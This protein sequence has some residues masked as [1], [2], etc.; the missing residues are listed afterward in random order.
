MPNRRASSVFFQS[1]SSLSSVILLAISISDS[2]FRSSSAHLSFHIV[3]LLQFRAE[4]SACLRALLQWPH[5]LTRQSVIWDKPSAISWTIQEV[6]LYQ[7]AG[8]YLHR[9]AQAHDGRR[10]ARTDGACRHHARQRRPQSHPKLE[11]LKQTKT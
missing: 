2:P 9:R 6:L 8:T 7:S 3:L 4:S 11:L 5:D 1:C 10:A